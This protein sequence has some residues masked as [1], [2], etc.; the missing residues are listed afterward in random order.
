MP[1]A[2]AEARPQVWLWDDAKRHERRRGVHQPAPSVRRHLGPVLSLLGALA[3]TVLAVFAHAYARFPGAAGIMA[4]IQQATPTPAGPAL[5][6][7]SEANNV[8]TGGVLYIAAVAVFALMKRVRG[9]LRR[10]RDGRLRG[11]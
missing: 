9:D 3:L 2:Q 8:P 6:F 4:A 5:A 11:D 1:M 10:L 7:P